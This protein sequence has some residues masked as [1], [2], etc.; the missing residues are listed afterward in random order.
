MK[1]FI[2]VCVFFLLL[3]TNVFASSKIDEIFKKIS[4]DGETV[5]FKSVKPVTEEES[6]LLLSGILKK[7]F[8]EEGYDMYIVCKAPEFLSCDLTINSNDLIYEYDSI[9]NQEIIKKGE[10]KKYKITAIYDEPTEFSRKKVENYI[11]KIIEGKADDVTKYY[12]IEDLVLINYYYMTGERS[13]LYNYGSP[14]I[15]LKFIKEINEITYGADIDFYLDIRMGEF[16]KT[17]SDGLGMMTIFYNDYAYAIKEKGIFLKNILYIP[18]TTKDTKEAYIEA[19][20][21][22]IDDY[23]GNDNIKVTYGGLLTSLDD[24][25]IIPELEQNN[26]GNYYNVNI[27]GITYNF[28]IVKTK[29]NNLSNPKYVGKNL[30]TDISISTND[31]F[32][33]LDADVK[34]SKITSGSE[35]ERI[36][37][38]LNFQN[39]VIYDLKLYSPST[40]KYITQLVNDFFEVNIPINEELKTKNLVVYY[41]DDNGIKIEYPVTIKDKVATFNTNHFSIYTLTEKINEDEKIDQEENKNNIIDN[42]ATGD[43]T[44]YYVLLFTI[45]LLSLISIIY[46]KKI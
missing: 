1:K 40:K 4:P 36:K 25:P 29:N 28:C 17:F 42:P 39:G 6:G 11:S 38:I 24:S 43:I 9:T 26:D 41:I 21:K 8:G 5:T 15:A 20:Q 12:E 35:Y 22:R 31:F 30:E 3:T 45:S 10:I 16:Y 44:I 2:C 32:V 18:E 23:L 46:L 14:G 27:S 33:P 19:A 13:G 37:K 34:A 7:K